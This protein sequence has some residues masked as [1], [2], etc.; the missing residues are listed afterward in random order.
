MVVN[1]T[2]STNEVI[3]IKTVDLQLFI[4]VFAHWGRGFFQ[5]D[6]LSP[7]LFQLLKGHD[8]MTREH[9]QNTM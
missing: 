9:L 8:L 7:A 6:R 5:W 4:V 1:D 2:V 3:A